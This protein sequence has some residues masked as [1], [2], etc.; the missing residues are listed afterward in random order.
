M[1]LDA[2]VEQLHVN[3]A[4]GVGRDVVA[5]AFPELGG[6]VWETGAIPWDLLDQE[7]GPDAVLGTPWIRERFRSY[8]GELACYIGEERARQLLRHYPY[9]EWRG[10]PVTRVNSLQHWAKRKA[11]ERAQGIAKRTGSSFTD[12]SSGSITE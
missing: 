7:Y 2:R 1:K 5:D 6:Q 11:D 3:S 4:V 9:D 8:Y 12:Q 10:F